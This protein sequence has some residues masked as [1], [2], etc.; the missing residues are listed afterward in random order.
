MTCGVGL[1][2]IKR[3]SYFV[4]C[5][6]SLRLG[7]RYQTRVE[8]YIAT[9]ALAAAVGVLTALGEAS[10]TSSLSFLDVDFQQRIISWL[11]PTSR[12]T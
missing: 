6:V 2:Y 12:E 10:E 11:D 3:G 5:Q 8:S 9:L 1:F 4:W 7:G